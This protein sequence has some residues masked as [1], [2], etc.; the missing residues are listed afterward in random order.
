MTRTYPVFRRFSLRYQVMNTLTIWHNHITDANLGIQYI[1][2]SHPQR[3]IRHIHPIVICSA[4][5]TMQHHFWRPF[6]MLWTS[7]YRNCRNRFRCLI[8]WTLGREI[9]LCIFVWPPF[10]IFAF[11]FSCSEQGNGHSPGLFTGLYEHKYYCK[12]V[13]GNVNV[14]KAMRLNYTRTQIFLFLASHEKYQ[15]KSL[16]AIGWESFWHPQLPWNE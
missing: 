1:L 4:T 16:T 6:K 13:A 7:E 3:T 2:N 11:L 14:H 5:N 8:C 15:N 10:F 12:C 9:T